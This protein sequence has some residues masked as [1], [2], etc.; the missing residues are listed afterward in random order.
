MPDRLSRFWQELKR[1]NVVRVIT[2]YAGA[3]F[4]IIELI[5]NIAGPLRLPEWTP[6]LVIIL[7]AIGFPIIIIFSWIYDVHPEGGVVKTVPADKVKS[8][9]MPKSSNS[10]K[11]ASYISFVVIIVLIVLNIGPSTGKEEILEKSIAVLPFRNDS[12]DEENVYFINGTMEAILDNLCKIKDLRVPGRTSVEQ[13]RG[14]AKSLHT[15][16]EELNV[17]YIL[18][19]SGQKIGKRILLNVQLIDGI[20]DHLLWSKPY[21]REIEQIEDLIDIQSE[22]AQQVAEE[23]HAVI[24]P[25]EKQLIE[26][27]PTTSLTAFDYYQRGMA[28]LAKSNHD[29]AKQLFHEAIQFDSTFAQAYVGLAL[30]YRS[31]HYWETALEEDFL[32]SVLVLADKALSID[33]RLSD[34]YTVRGYYYYQVGE[35]DRAIH[36]FDRAVEFNPNNGRAY[37]LRGELYSLKDLDKSMKDY[38]KAMELLRGDQLPAMLNSMGLMYLRTGFFE[39]SKYYYSEAFKLTRDSLQYYNGLKMCEFVTGNFSGSIE[40]SKKIQALDTT[41]NDLSNTNLELDNWFGECYMMNGDFLEALKYYNKWLEKGQLRGQNALFGMHRIG[42]AYWMNGMKKEGEEYLMKQID[43]SM[44]I[45]D[46]GHVIGSTHRNYY[47]LAATYAFLGEKD[48][49][50]DYLGIYSNFPIIDSWGVN[51]LRHDPLFDNIRDEP[52]FKQ[53]VRDVEAKFQAE[54]ERIRQWLEVNDML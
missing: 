13:Y 31:N 45:L 3:A 11:I 1:R 47:D 33:N 9:D 39:K 14:V 52:E 21:E 28:E 19:G 20:N 49:A 15:I 22:I 26:N 5:N 8:E 10:W 30:V 40:Y 27:I 24:E 16:A 32:D 54:H 37:R 34:A 44:R 35:P 17:S 18:Q 42:W 7:L 50:Y 12:P 46:M 53:I 43:Y 4:V 6:T 51:Y 2:V 41:I 48:R 23:I 38:H 29:Y 25:E 36:D